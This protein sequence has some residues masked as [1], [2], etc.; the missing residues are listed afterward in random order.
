MSTPV[1]TYYHSRSAVFFRTKEQWGQFA[2]P[3][4]DFP[5]FLGETLIRSTEHLYQALRFPDHPELQQT[6]LD[7]TWA[8]GAKRRAYADDTLTLTTPAWV[9]GGLNVKAMHVV[10]ALKLAL[11]QDVM[12][13]LMEATGTQPIVERSSRDTFWGA[14]QDADSPDCLRGTN[15]LG[16]IWMAHR[17]AVLEVR[18]DPWSHLHG[19]DMAGFRL[20]G[21]PVYDILMQ[22]EA[23]L[24]PHTLSLF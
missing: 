4:G 22:G 12:L 23:N 3:H 6:I 14:I 17:H 9:D 13:P 20:L 21:R 7:V 8:I 10:T 11:Y 1:E 18:I 16:K 2:N 5:F 15:T 24:G 19:L